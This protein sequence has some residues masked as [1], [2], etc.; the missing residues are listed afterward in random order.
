LIIAGVP[1]I[2]KTTLAR[3]LLADAVLDGY[4][5]LEVPVMLKS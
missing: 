1:G 4:D 2:G 5:V 3:M